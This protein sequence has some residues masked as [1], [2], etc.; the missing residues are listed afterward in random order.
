MEIKPALRIA[1]VK[2]YFFADLEKTIDELKE[3]GINIIRLDMGSPDMAP[4]ESI[5]EALVVSARRPDVHGYSQSG[6]TF[7]LRSAF[8]QYYQNRFGVDLDPAREV[9]G[10]IGSKEGI[11]NLNQVLINPGDLVLLP[12]PCYPVYRTGVVISQAETYSMPLL[13]E[14]E[15]LPDFDRIPDAVAKKAK[16]MWLNYPNNPTGAI[17]PLSF[18]E[19]AVDFAVKNNIV[20]AHDAPYVDVCFDDYFAPSILQ[21]SGA[22]EVAIEFNSLSKTYNMA[23]WRVGVAVGN[24]EIVRLLRLIKSQMDSSH[25][26]PIMVAAESALLDDQSWI[27][28]RNLVYQRRRDIIVKT[29]EELGFAIENPKASLYVWAGLPDGFQDSIEFCDTL[30]RKTGVSITP[31]IVFGDSGA[32]YVRISLVTPA[33]KLV[34][35]MLRMKDWMKEHN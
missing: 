10:L 9:L 24:P 32:G 11:F 26:T 1:P 20:I 12:D 4:I 3:S 14:N 19:E 15:F 17:A 31:G 34:E 23:G 29:M 6:G 28:S 8:A 21:V 5:I 25:F 2:P 18:F 35:A 33:E 16:L 30:L 13:A 22:K 7:G 27:R